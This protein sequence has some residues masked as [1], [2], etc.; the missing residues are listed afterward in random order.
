MDHKAYLNLR[1][2]VYGCIWQELKKV[3]I[4]SGNQI[5]SLVVMIPHFGRVHVMLRGDVLH[6]TGNGGMDRRFSLADPDCLDLVV[7]CLIELRD[8]NR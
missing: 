8:G 4:E 5:I 2:E 1:S 7:K 6:V 3:G